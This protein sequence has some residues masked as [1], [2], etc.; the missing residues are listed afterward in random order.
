MEMLQAG[1]R[2]PPG[3]WILALSTA[4]HIKTHIT[5]GDWLTY[6]MMFAFDAVFIWWCWTT[7][8]PVAVGKVTQ[9]IIYPLKSA[10]GVSVSSA[11]LD[12]FGLAYDRRWM[13]VDKGGNF[14][15][16]RRAPRLAL[17]EAQLPKS[18]DEPL[19]LQDTS[20]KMKPLRVPVVRHAA[21]ESQVRCWDDHISA[22]D[23]GDAAAAWL[24]AVL[25]VDD[26]RL[27]RMAD[28]A[29]RPCSPKYAPTTAQTAFTDGFPILLT[30]DASLAQLNARLEARGKGTIPMD[31]FRPN[32]VIGAA[33]GSGEG[34]ALG[35]APG[36]F[37][38]DE[39]AA[40]TIGRNGRNEASFRVVKP[41]ARCKMPT[42]NQQTGVPDGRGSSDAV[43]G[44]DDT[45]EGGGPVASAEP[46]ATLRTFRTGE[47]LGYKKAGWKNDVFFGQNL[48]MHD[49]EGATIRVGDAVVATPRRRPSWLAR[50]VLG[51]H[52]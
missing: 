2:D 44:A 42:I 32:L 6:S 41:C 29:T 35:M 37:A 10:R 3:L 23:Q 12:A 13:V 36:P 20:G 39:W 30:N 11:K 45:D 34:G 4:L 28:G 5:G 50:G 47:I 31:R 25:G 7:P 8:Q 38:E 16:Q 14:M 46:T 40:L 21:E 52:Y 26:V 51:V 19:R 18:D 24:A 48:V 49:A 27:V 22:V 1:L 33:N 15:S 43:L 17:I 9:L